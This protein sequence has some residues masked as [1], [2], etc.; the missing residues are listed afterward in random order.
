MCLFTPLIYVGPQFLDVQQVGEFLF[1][2][3]R[4]QGKQVKLQH[5]SGTV[6]IPLCSEAS[7]CFSFLH[8]F[9]FVSFHPLIFCLTKGYTKSI[10]PTQNRYHPARGSL[11]Y[12]SVYLFCSAEHVNLI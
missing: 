7:R 4:G 5:E 10:A 2:F 9:C 3:A 6:C 8:T 11:P 12:L 1:V